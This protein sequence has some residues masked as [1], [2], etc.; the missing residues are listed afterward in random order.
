MSPDSPKWTGCTWSL[1][2][3]VCAHRLAQQS[4]LNCQ[5]RQNASTF[6]LGEATHTY[7]FSLI[8]PTSHKYVKAAHSSRL[9]RRVQHRCQSSRNPVHAPP[10]T[11]KHLSL[12]LCTS[13]S[14]HPPT[15]LA[16]PQAAESY[17]VKSMSLP[18]RVPCSCSF[19]HV[20]GTVNQARVCQAG[21][22]CIAVQPVHCIKTLLSTPSSAVWHDLLLW[23]LEEGAFF[24]PSCVSPRLYLFSVLHKGA[25]EPSSGSTSGQ[26]SS[27]TK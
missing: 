3:W 22:P 9:I 5:W 12:P 25:V 27:I 19:K 17:S 23:K 10:Y 15:Y 16:T 4:G 13:L 24:L 20:C 6:C 7:R 21:L 2:T 1:Q 11:P 14:A 8:S 18:S 26:S